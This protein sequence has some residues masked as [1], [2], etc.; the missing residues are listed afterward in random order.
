MT[1][2]ENKAYETGKTVGEYIGLTRG[3][4]IAVIMLVLFAIMVLLIN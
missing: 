2:S 4:K 1:D 3:L